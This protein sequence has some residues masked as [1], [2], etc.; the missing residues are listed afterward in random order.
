MQ[1][2]FIHLADVHLGHQQYGANARF[3]DFGRAFLEGIDY[4]VHAQAAFVI[5][6]GDLFHKKAIGPLTLLQAVDGLKRLRDAGIPVIAVEGNHDRARYRDERSWLDFLAAQ[7]YLYLLNP[8]FDDGALQLT[9]WDEEAGAGSYVD[10]EGVRIYGA[11]YFGASTARYLEDIGERLAEM[12]ISGIDYTVFVMHAG[13]EGEVPHYGGTLTHKQLAPLREHVDYLALGHIHKSYRREGWIY[14]PGSPE[15]CRIDEYKWKRGFFHITVDTGHNPRHQVRLIENSRRPFHRFTFDVHKL[16]S[17]TDCYEA[18][19][20][21]L[22]DRARQI[23]AGSEPVVELTLTGILEFSRAELDVN[24]VKRMVEE[25]CH[26]LL[27]R[28]KNNTTPSEFEVG[29]A[30]DKPRAELE[31]SVLTDLIQRDARYR[32]HASD[33]AD[34]MIEIKALTLSEST[35]ETIVE[36]V[37]ERMAQI[38]PEVNGAD[39]DADHEG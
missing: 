27:A 26:P 4:A 38:A 34:L 24:H 28:V 36:H 11:Q 16:E 39:P 22:A 17:P 6:A 25:R 21:F 20:G 29:V 10:I 9:P 15:T 18:L 31:R 32:R 1:M 12:D 13:L 23:A 5:I 35:P 3:N 30:H 2:E 37:R 14:N 7:G 33:W 19:E 8:T